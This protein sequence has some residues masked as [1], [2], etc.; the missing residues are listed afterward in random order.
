MYRYEFEIMEKSSLLFEK[1]N[2]L[3]N[4]IFLTVRSESYRYKTT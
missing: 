3:G 2:G 1:S 4:G